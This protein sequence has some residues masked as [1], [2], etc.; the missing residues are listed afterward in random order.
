MNMVEKI[1]KFKIIL[2]KYAGMVYNQ[3]NNSRKNRR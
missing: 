1:T 3:F 2:D